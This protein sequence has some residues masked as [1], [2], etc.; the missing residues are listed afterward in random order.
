MGKESLP[1]P[2]NFEPDPEIR[3]KSLDKL[4]NEEAVVGVVR[5]ADG[6]LDYSKSAVMKPRKNNEE[7]ISHSSESLDN[8]KI[9]VLSQEELASLSRQLLSKSEVARGVRLRQIA[10][11]KDSSPELVLRE[12]NNYI[13]SRVRE[14]ENGEIRHFHRTSI[15]KFRTIAEM[16]R[17]VSKTKLSAERPDIEIPVGS[18]SDTV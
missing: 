7:N 5:N 3:K 4:N 9:P 18:T 11:Q 10:K 2:H 12:L 1:Q 8:E 16:G 14:N 17:L 15:D 6:S 13:I